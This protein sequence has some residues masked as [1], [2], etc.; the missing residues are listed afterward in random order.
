MRDIFVLLTVLS[1][2]P[3]IYLRP[4]VGIL[5]WC[6]ISYMNPHRLSWGFAYGL[7]V[8]MI[9]GLATLTAWVVSKEP[10]RLHI[11]ALSGLL[12]AFVIWMTFAN[13]FA[14]VPDEAF[15]KWNQ[16]FKILLMTFV[17]MILINNR[18]R[19]NALIWVIVTSL[20]FF[21]VKGGIFTILGGGES[22]VWGPPRSFIAD[23]NALA[24]ALLMVLP[25][26]RYLQLHTENKLLRLGMYGA[27]VTFAFSIIGSQSRG[28]FLAASAMVV[29]LIWKSRRRVVFGLALMCLLGVSALFVPQHWI[30]R[31]K[32]IETYQEDNS[33]MT[34]IEVWNFAIKVAM[35][36][37]IV[38]GGFRVPYDRQIYLHYI[39]DAITGQ[40]RNFHS[41]YFEMLGELG[42]V[43][44]FIYLGVLFSAWRTGSWIIR[45]T[46][47]KPELL[48]ANDLARMTQVSLVGFSVAGAFQ[49]LAYFDLYFH[50]IC[51]LYASKLIVSRELNVTV[52]SPLSLAGGL[53]R[54]GARASATSWLGRKQ[55]RSGGD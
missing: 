54:L 55:A 33:A 14:L 24:M 46:K 41:I 10:K 35:D 26:I 36:H 3:M 17:T 53:G 4:H 18:E 29:F 15:D 13:L 47:N 22:R 30:D 20:A 8:A 12:L 38:G 27:M 25:L 52:Q 16:S 34:R 48:W 9:V 19:L 21:G 31:M 42:F 7:P 49:N 37:P 39:P 6:W 5:A 44:L 45:Q 1:T 28:A 23:N 32:T 51:I 11:N 40:G 43:G 2:V 50:L